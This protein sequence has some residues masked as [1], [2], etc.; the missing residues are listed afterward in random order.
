M[1]EIFLVC[2]ILFL[3]VALILFLL[4]DLYDA[5]NVRWDSK[6]LHIILC[7]LDL[8]QYLLLGNS[9]GQTRKFQKH[10]KDVDQSSSEIVFK[11]AI[12]NC[13]IVDCIIVNFKS[14]N[15]FIVWWKWHIYGIKTEN[16]KQPDEVSSP[17]SS[18]STI[19]LHISTWR[20]IFDTLW[21]NEELNLLRCK[22]C[23]MVII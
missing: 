20:N 11:L 15:E 17:N 23:R 21:R 6:N 19:V 4:M 10:A 13:S 22:I 9:N 12:V 5:Y 16:K 7:A 2:V 14:I 1:T 3:L 18:T 8:L